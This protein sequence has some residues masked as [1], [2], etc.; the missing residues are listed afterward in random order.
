MDAKKHDCG[1]CGKDCDGSLRDKDGD[2]LC[3]RCALLPGPGE[4][5]GLGIQDRLNRVGKAALIDAAARHGWSLAKAAKEMDVPH[6]S[7]YWWMGQHAPKEMQRARESGALAKFAHVTTN[8][9][10]KY[11]VTS[12]KE[13]IV[14]AVQQAKGNMAVAAKANGIRAGR[15]IRE[16]IKR[17]APAEYAEWQAWRVR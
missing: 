2:P 3:L 17:L 14:R 4:P 5:Q 13:A 1:G 11:Q 12:S 16:A 6:A 8:S 15:T 7:L 10:P 9:R